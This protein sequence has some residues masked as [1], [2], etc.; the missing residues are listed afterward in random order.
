MHY[1]LM[2]RPAEG[3][4][5]VLYPISELHTMLR[6]TILPSL[7]EI[8]SLNQHHPLPQKIFAA[9]EVVVDKK[10]RSSMAAASIHSQA[11]FSEARSLADAILREVG[12]VAQ[13]VDS[14][15]GAFL[16]GRGADIVVSGVKIGSF[17]EIHPE[18]LRNFGLEQPAVGIEIRWDMV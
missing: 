8:L 18:V 10:T 2:R 4:T 12:V 9:G 15:D 17:G 5:R 1:E 11:N 16:P 7:L 13:I 6:T 14:Q 3:M